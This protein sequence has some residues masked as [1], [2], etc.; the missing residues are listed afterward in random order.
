MKVF[1][2]NAPWIAEGRVGVR[3]GSRWP[4]T[5]PIK[6]ISNLMEYLPFPFFLAYSAAVIERAGVD[7]SVSDGIAEG[8]SKEQFI[9]KIAEQQPE[10]VLLETST[11]SIGIDLAI[12]QQI[13]EKTD[14]A[15]ALSGPHVSV[16]GDGIIKEN[17]FV[18]YVLIGEYEYTLRDLV[19]YLDKGKKPKDVSGLV[20][21]DGSRIINNGRRSLI[22]NLDE[23]PWPARHLFPMHAYNDSFAG[24]PKPNVQLWASRGCPYGCIFCLWPKVMYGGGSYRVRSPGDVVAELRS[25]IDEYKFKAFYF[26][27]DTFDIGKERV[28]ELSR[29]IKEAGLNLPWAAMARADTADEETLSAMSD[30]G[31]YAIKYG[32]ESGVQ[33]ILDASGKDLNL[34]KVKESVNITKNLGVK[35]HLTFTFGLPG[36]TKESIKK[37]IDFVLK[38]DPDSAQFSLVTPFPG[39]DYFKQLE[40]ESRLSFTGWGE[41]DGRCRIVFEPENLSKKELEQALKDATRAW[42]KHQLKKKPLYHLAKSVKDP[43]YLIKG[44]QEILG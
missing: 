32:V 19:A 18:D 1:I 39:T 37:T 24:M 6:R 21:R 42:K 2:G 40:K 41:F 7:V 35:T 30:A 11:P 22:E 28:M 14:A 23:L 4:Y 16:L 29:L 3:A 10:L 13:K 43:R 27:D 8:L 15:M 44:V 5:S 31:L 36:E 9:E 25:A 33:S 20:Y 12:T 38:V 26:D 34:S 17:K